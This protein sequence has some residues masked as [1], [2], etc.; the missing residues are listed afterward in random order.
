MSSQSAPE[1]VRPSVATRL[2]LV[3]PNPISLILTV[4]ALAVVTSVIGGT[5][6]HLLAI[7]FLF[8]DTI[9]TFLVS[10]VF[11]VRWGVLVGVVSNLLL[12]ITSGPTVI[13]FALVQIVIAVIVGTIANRWGC[14]TRTAPAAGLLV[15]VFAPLVGTA[16]AVGVYGGLTGGV[17]DV[18][19]LWLEQAGQ[20]AFGAAFWPR[21]GSNLI[22]KVLTAFLVL[23]IVKAIPTSLIKPRRRVTAAAST[24]EPVSA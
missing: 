3:N 5:F 4:S 1:V 9:G 21:L 22:D 18:A 10:A 16:I 8:L 12:G 19:V 13:P 17:L 15:A 2:T 23:A 20:E 24:A 11:G 14:T 7:P 6:V